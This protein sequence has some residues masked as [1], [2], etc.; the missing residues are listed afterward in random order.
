MNIVDMLILGLILLGALQGYR[1]GFLSGLANLLGSLGG[2]IFAAHNY[3]AVLRA[4]E[5]KFPLHAWVEPYVFKA[6]WGQIQAQAQ[7]MGGNFL[8]SII[9]L[10]LGIRS[11]ETNGKGGPLQSVTQ[12]ILEEAAHRLAATITE[13]ILKILAFTLIFYGF[14]LLV[15][16]V[17]GIFLR[18]LGAFGGTVNHGGGMLL[19]A[20]TVIVGLAVLSGVISPFVD[21]GWS[22][23]LALLAQSWFYPHFLSLFKFLDRIFAVQIVPKLLEPL[24]LKNIFSVK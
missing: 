10:P 17:V 15:H 4:L 22:P 2:L 5:N 9:Q 13:N 16:L 11:L 6:I 7:G 12:G 24:Q 3:E 8:G 1:R 21:S 14:F 20:V 18:P 23:K 19:G